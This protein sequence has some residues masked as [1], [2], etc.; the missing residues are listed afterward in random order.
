MPDLEELAFVGSTDTQAFLDNASAAGL[1]AEQTQLAFANYIFETLG[2][3][4]R[5]FDYATPFSDSDPD[6]AAQFVR[7]FVHGDW[8]D[9][10]STVQAGPSP[11]EQG[12][13]E[14]FHRIEDD[15]DAL[16]ADL[17]RLIEAVSEMRAAIH[18]RQQELKSAINI[19]HGDVHELKQHHDDGGVFQPPFTAFP[20]FPIQPGVMHWNQPFIPFQPGTGPVTPGGAVVPGQPGINPFVQP[21]AP[22]VS[23]MRRASDPNSGTIAGMEAYRLAESRFNG[24][25]VEVWTTPIGTLLTPIAE[26]EERDAAFIEPRMRLVGDLAGWLTDNESTIRDELGDRFT[27]GALR[28]RFGDVRLPG[29]Q[30]LA[31]A[32]KLLSSGQR[33]TRIEEVA[34][35][36]AEQQGT[37]IKTSGNALSAVVG[38]IGLDQ[39]VESV[40]AARIASFKAVPQRARE[41][42]Q[43]LGI[44]TIDALTEIDTGAITE[45]LGGIGL[46]VTMGEVAGWRAMARTLGQLR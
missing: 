22:I 45:R 5:R 35:A 6:L 13:N 10:E 2:S 27:A 23:V 41:M 36:V 32:T 44:D 28:E 26:A 11:G 14:R 19:I 15:L 42:M 24:E 39:N 9:G 21:G 12:F 25:P 33:F 38:A 30:T 37:T 8:I 46:E 31:D 40:G 34:D 1:T 18:A 29:D 20:T 4:R 3:R 43:E 17:A 16:A 7:S